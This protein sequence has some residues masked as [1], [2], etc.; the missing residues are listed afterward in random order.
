VAFGMA[1]ALRA[2]ARR[3]E[4]R[5]R[6]SVNGTEQMAKSA[7]WVSFIF[8]VYVYIGYPLLL[9]MLRRVFRRPVQRQRCEPTVSVIIA[10]HDE[11]DKIETKILNLLELDYPR[12]KLQ[13]VIAL[14][15]PTDG[16]EDVVWKYAG[17]VVDVVY[18]FPHRG[19]AQ[20]LNAAVQAA[21]NDILVFCDARQRLERSAIRELVASFADP[22]VGAVSG[23]LVLVDEQGHEASDGVGLYWRYEK[24]LRSMESDVHSILGATGA[25]YALRRELFQTVPPDTILDDVAIP[26]RA[27]L[28]GQRV[29]F[30]PRALAYDR[31]SPSPESEYSRKVRTLMGNFQL[32][33]LMPDL[34]RPSKNPVFWQFISHKVGRLLVPYFLAVLFIANVFLTDEI[35]YL[36]FFALQTAF[37][38]LAWMGALLSGR[39]ASAPAAPRGTLVERSTSREAA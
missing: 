34:L 24:L 21:E 28:E 17:K 23:E 6:E 22:T 10:A 30:E 16:T 27:V 14:D 26:I 36:V 4:C 5:R 37:Y 25:L 8:I 11:R 33:A 35:P 20:A 12:H 9:W 32:L 18:Y 38:A 31:V 1:L 15:A 13:V 7:F 3:A 2:L 19:K 39:L 29:V